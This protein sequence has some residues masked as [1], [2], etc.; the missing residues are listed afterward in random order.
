MKGNATSLRETYL[1]EHLCR[2][3][4]DHE[5]VTIDMLRFESHK[6]Q[7]KAK[8][9]FGQTSAE[10]VAKHLEQDSGLVEVAL[11]GQTGAGK[12]TLFNALT[13]IRFGKVSQ[14]DLEAVSRNVLRCESDPKLMRGQVRIEVLYLS[15]T[16]WEED[17]NSLKNWASDDLDELRDILRN[18]GYTTRNKTE[19]EL[20]AMLDEVPP[21]LVSKFGKWV[22]YNTYSSYELARVALSEFDNEGESIAEIKITANFEER[23]PPN[24]SLVDVPGLGDSNPLRNNKSRRFL[25]EKRPYVFLCLAREAG[26]VKYG[27]WTMLNSV[28]DYVGVEKVTIV[29]TKWDGTRKAIHVDRDLDYFQGMLMKKYQLKGKIEYGDEKD[30]SGEDTDK[31]FVDDTDENPDELAYKRDRMK[32]IKSLQQIKATI[33]EDDTCDTDALPAIV[34]CAQY[35]DFDVAPVLQNLK[36]LA[37]A[38][39]KSLLI[40]IAAVANGWH[41]FERDNFISETENLNS[42]TYLGSL[43]TRIRDRAVKT[44][45]MKYVRRLLE[46]QLNLFGSNYSGLRFVLKQRGRGEVMTYCEK[47]R[48][49][50]FVD[51]NKEMLSGFE[52]STRL[53]RIYL[54]D[55][56]G[57]T[58][59]WN[60]PHAVKSKIERLQRI[61]IKDEFE[62]KPIAVIAEIMKRAYVCVGGKEAV[63]LTKANILRFYDSHKEEI[64]SAV[65]NC[66]IRVREKAASN[67]LKLVSETLS[68]YNRIGSLLQKVTRPDTPSDQSMARLRLHDGSEQSRVRKKS[69]PN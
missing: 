26:K 38:H 56:T 1:Y 39:G 61:M 50:K 16:Q 20:D 35:K 33:R 27:P 49:R 58:L 28:D 37:K 25:K 7:E 3:F 9:L 36:A 6:I 18:L 22:T 45:T 34:N 24:I 30:Y 54:R 65:A 48:Q 23:L 64:A 13:G 57:K 63:K 59:P 67:L 5:N 42:S 12:S 4:A 21:N 69:R 29:R 52:Q 53:L 14:Y 66:L 40:E 2:K 46:H 10:D 19:V 32:I 8:S 11:I 44:Q 51:L 60:P 68:D 17:R 43:D 31:D 55:L 15:E 47:E 41:F 62:S